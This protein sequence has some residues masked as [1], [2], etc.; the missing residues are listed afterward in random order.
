MREHAVRL[1]NL[2]TALR[3]AIARQELRLHYQPIVSLATSQ[4]AG[5]EALV[6]WLHPDRGLLS[7]ADFIPVAEQTELIIPITRWV[8]EEACRQVRAW[9]AQFPAISP[10]TVSMNLTGRYL[11]KPDLLEDIAAI[12]SENGLSPRNLSLEITERQI[13]EN[14]EFISKVVAWLSSFGLRLSIDSFGTGYS[15]ISYLAGFPIHALK[16]DRSFV[17]NLYGDEKN[18]AIVRSIVSLGH[19]LGLDVIAEGVE[20]AEQLD[21]LRTVKCHYG[22]GYYFSQPVDARTAAGLLAEVFRTGGKK[23]VEISR[24]RTFDLFAG[25]SEEELAEIAQSCEELAVLPETLVIRQGQ[26][27]NEVFLMEEGSVSV[28]RELADGPRFV[29]VLQ[30]PAVFGEMA[31]V[32]PERIRTGSVK[33]MSNLR[34]LTISVAPFLSFL[35]RFP[36][37]KNKLRR[38]VAARSSGK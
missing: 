6:R 4:I 29:A 35:R 15:S 1:R 7:P 36:T 34:L 14:P 28:Y 21:F 30:A 10:L 24:L 19:N 3:Q 13:M 2:E 38:L 8:L 27:G 23:K 18:S 9:Q 5:F 12:L 22:Q 11:A 33:A 16:I 31:I 37:L 25:L 26:V 17:Q 20:K 32:N